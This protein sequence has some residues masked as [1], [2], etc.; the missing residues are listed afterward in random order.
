MEQY[1]MRKK[2]ETIV[3]NYYQYYK[4]FAHAGII[5]Y[6]EGAVSWIIPKD[7]EKGPALAFGIHLDEEN[8]GEELDK[9]IN[10]ICAKKVPQNW[11]VT[12]DATPGNIIEIMEK[13]GFRNLAT[14]ESEPE[15]A[16]LLNKKEFKPYRSSDDSIV[17]RKVQTK[18][19]FRLWISIVNT[20]LHGWDMIDADNYY[21]WIQ[22]G[23]VDVYLGEIEGIPVSTAAT[24]RNGKVASL[25]FVST[26]EEYRRKKKAS[27]V[28]SKAITDL[29]SSGI[30]DVTLSACG[31][32][33]NLYKKFGFTSYFNN[34]IM[35]YEISSC[36]A[37]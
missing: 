11:V 1:V 8:A 30:K 12:P 25:D 16:M 18:E 22:N 24:I 26:L 7:G 17:C 32:S 4:S 13:R 37:Y 9:L 15:P 34:T 36:G 10:G 23:Y 28:C 6:H 20:T 29:F 2:R 14:E 21:T 33:V 35:H 5:D 3:S 31:E 27:A 19:D